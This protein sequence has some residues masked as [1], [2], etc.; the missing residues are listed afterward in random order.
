MNK[1]KILLQGD[2]FQLI[3]TLPPISQETNPVEFLRKQIL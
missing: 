2:H 1:V 3:T